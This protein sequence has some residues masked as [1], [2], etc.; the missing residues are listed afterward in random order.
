MLEAILSL[1]IIYSTSLILSS[2]LWGRGLS[3]RIYQPG[4]L[5]NGV[6]TRRAEYETPPK[7]KAPTGGLSYGR[8]NPL[9]LSISSYLSSILQDRELSYQIYQPGGVSHGTVSPTVGEPLSGRRYPFGAGNYLV[10]YEK[11]LYNWNRWIPTR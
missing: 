4:G 6:D 5:S 7:P 3:Y 8:D 1:S 9:I 11:I 2:I 10:E